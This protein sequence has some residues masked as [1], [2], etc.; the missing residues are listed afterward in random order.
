M[1][2]LAVRPARP[3]LKRRRRPHRR[4]IHTAWTASIS[5]APY[6]YLMGSPTAERIR[7]RAG[8]SEGGNPRRAKFGS[9][10]QS[11]RLADGGARTTG[12][13]GEQD[14]MSERSGATPRL[15]LP[16]IPESR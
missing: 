9:D 10:G 8:E 7:Q 3:D 15:P 5:T 13:D 6:L 16:Q 4:R 11:P 12:A 2:E 14:G 1:V